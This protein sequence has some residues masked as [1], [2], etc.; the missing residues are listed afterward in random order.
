M[1]KIRNTKR[2]IREKQQQSVLNTD[3]FDLNKFNRMLERSTPLQKTL[4]DGQDTYPMFEPLLSDIWAGFYKINP[5]LKEEV[6]D[7]IATNHNLMDQVLHDEHY[8][9]FH[10][11]TKLNDLSSAVGSINFGR[12]VMEW[13][14]EKKKK[15]EELEDLMNQVQQEQ[16]QSS[17]NPND[18]SNPPSQNSVSS[19]AMQQLNHKMQEIFQNQSG[20]LSQALARAEQET[21]DRTEEIESLIGGLGDDE[22]KKVPAADQIELAENLKYS[23]KMKDVANYLGRLKQIARKKQ[24]SKHHNAIDRSG[25]TFGDDI[26]RLLPQELAQLK[27]PKTKQE[28]LRRYSEGKTMMYDKKGKMELGKGPIVM[29]C[30]QSGSMDGQ[31]DSIAKAFALA[32]AMIA[33]KQRRDFVFIPFSNNVG[34]PIFFKKG[35]ITPREIVDFATNFQG[36][37]TKYGPVLLKA[38]DVIKKEKAFKQADILFI[39]D[40]DPSDA[41]FIHEHQ[42][43]KPFYDFKEKHHV[44]ITSLIIGNEVR[45][46]RNV[47]PFSDKVV[48]AKNLLQDEATDVFSI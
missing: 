5:S 48:M 44:H 41:Y 47:K 30:D 39:T 24:K 11:T 40:G 36:G 21:N 16:E 38:K 15:D 1:L 9:R 7:S 20:E 34:Q 12:K 28:F 6:S 23:P 22:L 42:K 18:D 31:P 19:E 29:C 35:A 2:Q 32:V 10:E 25:V 13:I 37:G 14:E 27:N 8:Q 17:D 46:D 45:S 4:I 26:E 33:K 3:L 43:F